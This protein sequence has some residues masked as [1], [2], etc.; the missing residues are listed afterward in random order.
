MRRRFKSGMLANV[1]L[2]PSTDLGDSP[3]RHHVTRARHSLRR[4]AVRCWRC[5]PRTMLP[6]PLRRPS[7]TG[8]PRHAH[9]LARC[10]S[11]GVPLDFRVRLPLA[12]RRGGNPRPCRRRPDM[13]LG[14]AV[15][16]RLDQRQDTGLDRVG[17]AGPRVDD[18]LKV[19]AG[20]LVFRLNCPTWCPP[21]LGSTLFFPCFPGYVIGLENRG[22]RKST[23]GS[24]PLPSALFR[25]RQVPPLASHLSPSRLFSTSY[26]R[27]RPAVSGHAGSPVA[28]GESR[29]TRR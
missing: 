24:N 16:A 19:R 28:K 27:H 23:G 4:D 21:G 17:Q 12:P 9:W 15:P 13:G 8:T 1:P 22:G 10:R 25:F 26:P 3:T 2:Q 5:W 11:I 6:W 18:R 20:L 29:A 7:T 14:L